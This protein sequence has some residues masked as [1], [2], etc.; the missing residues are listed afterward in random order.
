MMPEA[1]PWNKG[2]P[3]G[4]YKPTG[5]V[6]TTAPSEGLL[7]LEERIQSAVMAKMQVPMEQDDM[8]DRVLSLEGQVQ[9]LLAKQQGLES[10]L[11]EFSGH[12]SQQLA[13]LQT[14]VNV[15]SQQL[16][17]HL[18]NQNQTIQSLFEQQMTQI[19]TLL[20]KRPRE[21]GTE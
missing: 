9:H 1:D 6:T 2:D 7:Q 5:P 19:R 13:S 14:Q 10:Q 4:G 12:H 8:P 17:G 20:A 21:D 18:E 15:Q 16:H 11:Q 3:W